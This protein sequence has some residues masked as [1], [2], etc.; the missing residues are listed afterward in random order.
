MRFASGQ[1][2]VSRK[3]AV[4]QSL[5]IPQFRDSRA[6]S[7]SACA[8]MRESES[9]GVR[10][11]SVRS[12]R[13]STWCRCSAFA[14]SSRVAVCWSSRVT[15][16]LAWTE[17]SVCV[18]ERALLYACITP[19]MMLTGHRPMARARRLRLRIA[20]TPAL[21]DRD[22]ARRQ[23]ASGGSS[24]SCLRTRKSQK[25]STGRRESALAHTGAHGVTRRRPVGWAASPS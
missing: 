18:R 5:E 13:P 10:A 16:S 4:T 22:R 1:F 25:T 9:D 23:H 12:S 2:C 14:P 21:D 24:R 7:S 3:A 20:G 17:M 8:W 6:R 19:R 15:L 11:S